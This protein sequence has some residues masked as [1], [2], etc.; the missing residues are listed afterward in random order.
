[1]KK[2]GTNKPKNIHQSGS[3]DLT[4]WGSNI[5]CVSKWSINQSVYFKITDERESEVKEDT[6]LVVF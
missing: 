1:M 5:T 4:N 6:S 3:S 2:T